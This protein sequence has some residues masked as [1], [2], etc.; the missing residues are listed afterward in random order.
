MTF[1]DE[2]EAL[3]QRLAELEGEL[4]ATRELVE[5]VHGRLDAPPSRPASWKR[6]LLRIG[7]CALPIAVAV[8]ACLIHRHHVLAHEAVPALR[9][10]P[11]FPFEDLVSQ[12]EAESPHPEKHAR[13]NGRVKKATGLPL[14]PGTACTLDAILR[15][16]DEA[17]HEATIT[18]GGRVLY[19]STDVAEGR[20]DAVAIS[21]LEV[22]G[23][24]PGTARSLLE[25]D[26][27]GVRL[28]PR[29][30]ADVSTEQG[31]ADVLSAPRGEFEVKI[32]FEPFSEPY[33]GSYVS[34]HTDDR[35]PFL[36]ARHAKLRVLRSRG[37]A[38]VAPDASCDAW[39]FPVW[40][41]Q[42]SPVCRVLVR[43]GTVSV[44]GGK[45]GFIDE[46]EMSGDEPVR[47]RGDR[48]ESAGEDVAADWDLQAGRLDLTYLDHATIWK[49]ELAGVTET[50]T[51]DVK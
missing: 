21:A 51:A 27:T 28:G 33:E 3:R 34:E 47:F 1:R 45:A 42:D 37:P 17:R 15:G 25:L 11:S 30:E 14:A 26:D 5:R 18:C 44:Y 19:R 6:K 48:S 43:C 49:L 20:S 8:G 16:E 36:A 22:P 38:P 13:W 50:P 23:P 10:L 32:Q 7:G 24:R 39:M 2:G 46:C 31:T 41:G 4:A 40:G 12:R 9:T 29:T 35:L